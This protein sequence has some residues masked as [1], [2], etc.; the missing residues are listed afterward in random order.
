MILEGHRKLLQL[1]NFLDDLPHDK[2]HMPTWVSRDCTKDSC[3][4]AGCA[5]GWAATIFKKEGWS[6]GGP[7]GAFIPVFEVNHAS[8]YGQVGFA[9]FFEISLS[10]AW[11]ITCYLH[12]MCIFTGDFKSVIKDGYREEYDL[13]SVKDI[14]PRHAADRIRKVLGAIAPELLQESNHEIV[15][16]LEMARTSEL[17]PVG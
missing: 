7:Y 3:G 1:A 6:I 2:F 15:P 13:K 12:N 17:S 9:K 16:Q 8:F 5:C 11:A 10:D 4:T 14:T